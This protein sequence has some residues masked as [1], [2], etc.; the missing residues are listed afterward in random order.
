MYV[1]V[2]RR[3]AFGGG[4]KAG[5]KSSETD[6]E[7][8]R[9]KARQWA[10]GVAEARQTASR[11]CPC[12]VR[13]PQQRQAWAGVSTRGRSQS[14]GRIAQPRKDQT[15]PKRELEQ[16]TLR[17]RYLPA[18][19]QKQRPTTYLVA[20]GLSSQ[21]PL[22]VIRARA[23]D[24]PGAGRQWRTRRKPSL[25]P[26]AQREPWPAN[27]HRDSAPR[28]GQIRSEV[29]SRFSQA[30][31]D[32]DHLNGWR[33]TP[34][35]AGAARRLMPNAHPPA[36][37]PLAV[38]PQGQPVSHSPIMLCNQRS[39]APPRRGPGGL[40]SP[41]IGGIDWQLAVIRAGSS[42]DS[43]GDAPGDASGDALPPARK[44]LGGH[45]SITIH[46]KRNLEAIG[47][48]AIG[49]VQL[50]PLCPALS[51]VVS[52]SSA[53]YSGIADKS[54][55]SHRIATHQHAHQRHVGTRDMPYYQIQTQRV[56]T[57]DGA[58]AVHVTT[59][60]APGG[61]VLLCTSAFSQPDTFRRDGDDRCNKL[62]SRLGR[63]DFARCEPTTTTTTP[64]ATH[65]ASKIGTH[66]SV[67]ITGYGQQTGQ[68]CTDYDGLGCSPVRLRVL[69]CCT[70]LC[71]FRLRAMHA[72]TTD[73]E[74]LP[75]CNGGIHLVRAFASM[76]TCTPGYSMACRAGRCDLSLYHVGR[77][78][79]LG[80]MPILIIPS[81]TFAP[82]FSIAP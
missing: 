67:I 56:S 27:P 12:N 46:R 29:Y 58:E 53:S 15:G 8:R 78:R 68:A 36:I 81:M 51:D 80:P 39:M 71:F 14:A 37:S 11:P 17:A 31:Y 40:R 75:D 77:R 42:G 33:G 25:H 5:E 28:I 16:G 18:G 9:D 61:F 54:D 32:P 49:S 26:Q 48:S 52:A 23:E 1:C 50:A 34:K 66:P 6:G 82:S 22:V 19:Q 30:L 69:R 44:S 3:F 62:V 4:M 41:P 59:E 10:S 70:A 24:A 74:V 64:S 13:C 55:A 20:Q 43:S 79:S 7:T 60:P 45:G 2:E 21:V 76:E 72:R 63:M 57:C 35:E 38:S 65:R 47:A 73:S